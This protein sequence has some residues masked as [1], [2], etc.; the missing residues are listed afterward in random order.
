MS[1]FSGLLRHR[2]YDAAADAFFEPPG[3]NPTPNSTPTPTPH[4]GLDKENTSLLPE[5]DVG[6]ALWFMIVTFTTVG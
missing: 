3:R 6:D 1:L 4:Q 2:C 5:H